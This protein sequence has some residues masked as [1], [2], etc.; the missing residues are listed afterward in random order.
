[1]T[2]KLFRFCK[3]KGGVDSA[4]DIDIIEGSTLSRQVLHKMRVNLISGTVGKKY[5]RLRKTE[6]NL[7]YRLLSLALQ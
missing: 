3:D 6:N 7:L 4:G 1:M 5:A 2:V